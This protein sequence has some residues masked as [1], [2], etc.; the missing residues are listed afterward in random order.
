MVIFD[1][2]AAIL[3]GVSVLISFV[4]SIVIPS[5]A[6]ECLLPA[7]PIIVA[8]HVASAVATKSVGEKDSPFPSLSTGASVP[9]FAPE[10]PWTAEQCN[11][12]S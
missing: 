5:K 9:S 8:I 2:S 10:G 3:R 1:L 4:A 6:M 7:I 12:P 11:C